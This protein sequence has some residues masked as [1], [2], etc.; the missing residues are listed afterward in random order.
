MRQIVRALILFVPAAC[1]GAAA[2][3]AGEH[4]FAAPVSSL[5]GNAELG[6]GVSAGYALADWTRPS[7]RGRR[8]EPEPQGRFG[9]ESRP[10]GSRGLGQAAWRS[11]LLPGW[12]Q[13]Y[14]GAPG[15]GMFFMGGEAAIWGTWGTF[16]TQEWLRRRTY[17]EMAEIFAGVSGDHSDEYWKI[18]GQH[19]NSIDYH[20]WLRFEGRREYGFGTVEYYAF[21]EENEVAETD[22]WVWNNV[23]RRQGYAIKRKSSLSAERHATYTLY[24][25]LVNRVVALVDTWRLSRQRDVIQDAL[26]DQAGGGFDLRSL[27]T[28]AGLSWRLTWQRPF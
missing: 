6:A 4:P 13:R 8:G 9:I 26:D 25:L 5:S 12:G 19:S 3:L 27:P 23:T 24:A 22:G 21:I 28:E 1:I 7:M 20:E 2:A 16:R 11:I 17:T 15:R 14:L 10:E 18:V